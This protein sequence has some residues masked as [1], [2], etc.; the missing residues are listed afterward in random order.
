MQVDNLKPEMG[1]LLE[2]F[3]ETLC[4]Y[5][6]LALTIQYLSCG[7]PCSEVDP[8]FSSLSF[9]LKDRQG[10]TNAAVTHGDEGIVCSP[11]PYDAELRNLLGFL[12]DCLKQCQPGEQIPSSASKISRIRAGPCVCFLSLVGS[13]W[14]RAFTADCQPAS[15]FKRLY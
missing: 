4:C 13:S 3:R 10:S 1:E 6:S 2:F 9:E 15:V 8:L 14:A 12:G 11:A 5:V 7:W